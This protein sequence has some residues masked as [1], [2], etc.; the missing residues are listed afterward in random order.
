MSLDAR[1]WTVLAI[2]VVAS[3]WI[4]RFYA[5][6]AR[7]GTVPETIAGAVAAYAMVDAG[8]VDVSAYFPP[9]S[10]IRL[11]KNVSWARGLR[12]R[13]K[14]ATVPLEQSETWRKWRRRP[15]STSERAGG[16]ATLRAM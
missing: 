10:S 8:T 6:N 7:L 4:A 12:R 16:V 11:R 9:R 3:P 14:C 13:G 15:V 2:L 1:R 5:Q